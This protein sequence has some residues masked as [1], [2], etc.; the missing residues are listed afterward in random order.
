MLPEQSESSDL[1]A[2]TPGNKLRKY[3]DDTYVIIPAANE[4]S[5]CA[6]LDQY[7]TGPRL[8]T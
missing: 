4:H 2:T 1:R 7:N 3:A 8:I 5:R 6:E